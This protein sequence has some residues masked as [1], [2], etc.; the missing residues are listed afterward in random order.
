[1]KKGLLVCIAL[2]MAGMLAACGGAKDTGKDTANVE[3]D[4]AAVDL[5]GF[6]QDLEK[7]YEWGNGYMVEIEDDMLD[8]YYPGLRDIPKKQFVARMPIMT[9]V[10]N[11]LVF[12]ETENEQDADKAA[13]ILK[14]HIKEQSEGGAWYPESM[15]AWGKG[16]V[17]QKGNYVAML[18]TG[19]NQ[20]EIKAGF[21]KLFA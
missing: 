7:T 17:I 20:A 5:N 21:E 6:Y 2:V 16:E 12:I 19:E 4:T 13:E 15:E 9:A 14:A 18:A 3:K 8:A 11:E 10:V 1:M